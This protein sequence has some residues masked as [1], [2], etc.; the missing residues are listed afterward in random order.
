MA[1]QDLDVDNL[2]L[3]SIKSRTVAFIIDDLS[4]TFIVLI[5]LWN[6][7]STVDGDFNNILMIINQA[8]LQVIL[9]KFIYQTFFIW[10]YGATIGKLIVKIRVIDFD[11]YGKIS[12]TN[13]AIRSIG[14][15]LSESIFYI[16]FI[17]AYY[18][19]AKQTLHDKFG[20]SLVVN[21]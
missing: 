17:F 2:Q 15:I 14:R 20:K 7:I 6:K 8:F 4:I 13:S 16:G 11:N 3:A 10:Y 19:E 21:E 12:L 9:L 18:T 1:K 5:L